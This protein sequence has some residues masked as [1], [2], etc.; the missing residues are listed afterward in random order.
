MT[1]PE[2]ETETDLR[3]WYVPGAECFHG[4]TGCAERSNTEGDARLVALD[5]PRLDETRA[6]RT[7][8]PDYYEKFDGPGKELHEAVVQDG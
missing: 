7:C 4:T 6:C 2:I 5:D 1:D 8:L 3:V